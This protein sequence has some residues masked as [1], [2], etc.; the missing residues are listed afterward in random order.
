[1]EA[2]V[3]FNY[4]QILRNMVHLKDGSLIIFRNKSFQAHTW[5]GLHFYHK[6]EFQGAHSKIARKYK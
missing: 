1:M 2:S 6:F 4:N 5:E 3:S